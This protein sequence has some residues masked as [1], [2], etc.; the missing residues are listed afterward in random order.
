MSLYQ[1][2]E[3]PREF[4]PDEIYIEDN[5]CKDSLFL[6]VNF[7]NDLDFYVCTDSTNIKLN[8]IIKV[9][10]KN[11]N[12]IKNF[13]SPEDIQNY[14]YYT[15]NKFIKYKDCTKLYNYYVGNHDKIIEI[16]CMCS[17]SKCLKINWQ[18]T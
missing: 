16:L 9:L 7:A 3:I 1:I 12:I 14:F 11:F 6:R 4:I 17:I 10:T 13:K 8:D 5:I 2:E 15:K 18:Q